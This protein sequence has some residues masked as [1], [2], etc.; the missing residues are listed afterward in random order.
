MGHGHI[1]QQYLSGGQWRPIYHQVT[2]SRRASL[3]AVWGHPHDRD[4][5]QAIQSKGYPVQGILSV[6]VGIERPL[7]RPGL[8]PRYPSALGI[9][10]LYPVVHGSECF[11]GSTWLG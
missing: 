11:R 2:S 9:T 8:G 7:I 1:E 5:H 3:E 6:P 4:Y 10:T